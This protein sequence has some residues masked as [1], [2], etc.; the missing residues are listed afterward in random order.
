[1]SINNSEAVSYIYHFCFTFLF[2]FYRSS[3]INLS[4]SQKYLAKNEYFDPKERLKI[5][6]KTTLA[7]I[8]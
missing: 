7:T 1:M 4:K 8:D 3:L 6:L 5:F 2:S